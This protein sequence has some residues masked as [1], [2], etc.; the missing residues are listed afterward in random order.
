MLAIYWQVFYWKLMKKKKGSTC[1]WP[2][3]L[4]SFFHCAVS[5]QSLW[6]SFHCSFIYKM[7]FL[8]LIGSSA[9]FLL[10]CVGTFLI[11]F[12][13]VYAVLL[14]L[15]LAISPKSFH[16]SG[17][18]LSFEVSGELVIEPLGTSDTLLQEGVWTSVLNCSYLRFCQVLFNSFS[19]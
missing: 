3:L 18:F 5:Q 8:L 2:P 12:L 7:Y 10:F 1:F 9:S 11:L 16:P 6:L 19:P 17:F 4:M 14:Y 13:N 15:S